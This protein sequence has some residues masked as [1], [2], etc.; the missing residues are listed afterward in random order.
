MFFFNKFNSLFI[1][2]SS[3]SEQEVN[4]TRILDKVIRRSD[5]LDK[6]SLCIVAGQRVCIFLS[7]SKSTVRR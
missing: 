7:V 4:I 3:P 6:E 1:L 5:T 2:S